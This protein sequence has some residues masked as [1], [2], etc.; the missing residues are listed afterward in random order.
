MSLPIKALRLSEIALS[1]HKE[2]FWMRHP[3]APLQDRSDLE[4]VIRRLRQS[5]GRD[6]WKLA[7]DI[8]ECL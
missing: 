4:L 5:G 1:Q 7:R 3:D 8:E 2:C 6:A